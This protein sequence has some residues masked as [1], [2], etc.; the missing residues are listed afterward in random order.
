M[1]KEIII[2]TNTENDLP[3]EIKGFKIKNP[4]VV[5]LLGFISF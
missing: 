2:N 4:K 1:E 5:V 3:L